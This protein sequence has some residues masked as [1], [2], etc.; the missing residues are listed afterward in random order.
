MLYSWM[1]EGDFC[2]VNLHAEEVIREHGSIAGIRTDGGQEETENL[3]EN[4]QKENCDVFAEMLKE[5]PQKNQLLVDFD[6]FG[7]L[8][9][10]IAGQFGNCMEE[11]QREENR[12]CLLSMTAQV[13]GY[14]KA[15]LT[16]RGIT[17]DFLAYKDEPAYFWGYVAESSGAYGKEAEMTAKADAILKSNLYIL[18]GEGP[19]GKRFDLLR[20]IGDG[21]LCPYYFFYCLSR[22]LIKAGLVSADEAANRNICFVPD[23][24]ESVVMAEALANLLGADAVLQHPMTEALAKHKDYIITRDVLHMGCELDGLSAAIVGVGAEVK[25]VACLVDI[26]TGIGKAK[27]KVSLHT[28]NLERGILNR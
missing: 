14:V 27:N 2:Y 1:N 20:I 17:C 26:H 7:E 5:A 9:E 4:M 23:N 22:K 6:G 13:A 24:A 11:L 8:T 15:E 10:E 21:E 28:I 3:S 16:K 12:I 25:G 19:K 18:M